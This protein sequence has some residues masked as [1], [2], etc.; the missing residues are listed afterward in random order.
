MFEFKRLC[1]FGAL[2]AL[3]AMRFV[4]T[5]VA[6]SPLDDLVEA[7]RVSSGAPGM[8]AAVITSD[9][10][11]VFASGV[12]RADGSDRVAPGDSFNIGSDAKAMLA[13]LVAQEVEAGRL[14]W[15]TTIG[16]ILPDVMVTA[17]RVYR[18]VTITQLLNHQ[19][20]LPQLLTIEDLAGVPALRGTVPQQRRQFARWVLRQPAVVPP[21]SATTYS[22]AGYVVA[23]AM[24]ERVAGQRYEQLMQRRLFSPLGIQAR[25]GWPA[26]GG[27]NQPW[28]HSYQDGQAIPVDPEEPAA[29]LPAW[30]NPAGNV[31]LCA[32]DFARFVQL[33]LRG[34]RGTSTLLDPSTFRHL[35]TP[36]LGY[37]FG[38]AV[39]ATGDG[40]QISFHAGSSDLFFAYM[41]VIPQLDIAAVVLANTESPQMMA[42]GNRLAFALM[43]SK[44]QP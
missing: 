29:K 9:S 30:A 39:S 18:N 25:F 37:A 14:R 28:G 19:A 17:R 33:H 26:A 43:A 1:R 13:T 15:D 40:L 16:D 23:A 3:A 38:W 42:V 7:E 5:I 4:P 2:A 12:R 35:H 32:R 27:R 10:I 34:L 6:A 20:G 36:T 44:V 8:T 24:L 31:S 11:D 41:I 22:N 21:G